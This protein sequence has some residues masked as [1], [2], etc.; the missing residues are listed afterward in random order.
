[1]GASKSRSSPN[2]VHTG[3]CT[4]GGRQV[5]LRVRQSRQRK[6][7]A[8]SQHLLGGPSPQSVIATSTNVVRFASHRGI[9]TLP[10]SHFRVH[11]IFQW[12]TLFPNSPSPDFEF[13]RFFSLALELICL[14]RAL[15][16]CH[17]LR[18]AQRLELA[19]AHELRVVDDI[20]KE[21]PITSELLDRP[22]VTF[23]DLA[24]AFRNIVRRM[25]EAS[26][27]GTLGDLLPYLPPREPY[28]MLH[29]VIERLSGVTRL[30]TIS[31]MVSPGFKFCLDDCEVFSR[32]QR[33]TVN[34]LVRKSR[35]PISWVV[36]AV[37]D[38]LESSE[39]FSTKQPLTDADRRVIS[40]NDRAPAE[41]SKLCQ[42]IASLRVYFSLPPHARPPL[43]QHTISRFFD[44]D[45]RFGTQDVNQ[46]IHLILNSSVSPFA[47]VVRA[48]AK[49]LREQLS[50][51]GI[52]YRDRLA[53]ASD[54]LP[55]YEAYLLIHWTGHEDAFIT[56]ASE[57]DLRRISEYAIRVA[58]DSFQAWMRRKTVAALLHLAGRLGTR[59]LPLAGC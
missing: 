40:L 18:V 37:G 42:A 45:A 35:F 31:G 26:G 50:L 59:R 4:S 51:L 38:T 8:P 24:R 23:P 19:A 9:Y 1:M 14:E 28:E 17:E 33:T 2:L 10:R 53:T 11:G 52:P 58:N 44:L 16:S 36:S 13:F 41:F 57:P 22:P 5:C 30:T 39:T 3:R 49:Q 55:Y 46:T 20:L 6:N 34:T 54:R 56:F 47:D 25:N 21:Y 32:L 27:R 29:F 43:A 12:K 15:T 48:A 7:Y